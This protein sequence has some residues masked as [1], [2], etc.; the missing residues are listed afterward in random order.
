MQVIS[1]LRRRSQKQ[2]SSQIFRPPTSAHRCLM[3]TSPTTISFGC[4]ISRD[5]FYILFQNSEYSYMPAPQFGGSTTHSICQSQAFATSLT[6]ACISLRQ[7]YVGGSTNAML[8][9]GSH[10]ETL[11]I[12]V[13]HH[14][15]LLLGPGFQKLT[16]DFPWRKMT[17][18][19]VPHAVVVTLKNCDA[20]EIAM[21]GVV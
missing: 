16:A 5:K 11:R 12:A 13:L 2:G 9:E 1:G 19:V 3:N 6:N 20:F 4:V 8:T 15:K 21:K 14:F 10:K 17:M 7:Q 18:A